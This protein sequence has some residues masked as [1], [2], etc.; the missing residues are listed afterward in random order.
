MK[1]ALAALLLLPLLAG[2]QNERR[3]LGQ[4][5]SGQPPVVAGSLI[6]RWTMADL[7]GGGAVAGGMLEFS[8]GSVAGTAGCNRLS[9]RWQENGATLT[10]GPLAATRMACAPAAMQIEQRVLA[11]LAGPLTVKHD[12]NQNEGGGGVTLIAADGRR[13]RLVPAAP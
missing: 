13:L 6:G 2:C 5:L 12:G 8:A 7:N 4:A 1:P 10:V 9:G 3:Q 11:L